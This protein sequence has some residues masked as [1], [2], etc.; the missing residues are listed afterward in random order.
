MEMGAMFVFKE[1]EPSKQDKLCCLV[2]GSEKG[3]AKSAGIIEPGSPL[4]GILF[5]EEN[6]EN[7]ARTQYRKNV[8]AVP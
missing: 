5:M 8:G 6:C 2:K 4:G 7:R 3:S 1:P